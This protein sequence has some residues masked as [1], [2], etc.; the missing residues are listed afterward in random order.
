MGAESVVAVDVQKPA[1][2]EDEIE[3]VESRGGK[4]V[5]PFFT[6]KITEEGIYANDGRFIPA[7]EVIV[8]IGE[9][10]VLDY[11]PDDESIQKFRG[12]WLIAGKD[13]SILPG[14]FAAGDVIKPGRLT[15]AIGDGIKAA[16]YADQYV[17]VV[18]SAS[19]CFD[20]S[21]RASKA[22][23]YCSSSVT[24]TP[25]PASSAFCCSSS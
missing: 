11:L 10:P 17:T 13:K 23:R 24:S 9:E 14:V 16:Y 20:N 1:A 25:F 6:D 4:L 22:L 18:R 19:I 15:D 12:S 2:F 8:S 3:Y 7:D 21:L 5:W